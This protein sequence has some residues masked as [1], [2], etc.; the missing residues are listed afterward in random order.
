MSDHED[1]LE[2]LQASGE[3]IAKLAENAELFSQAAEAFR[4]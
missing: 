4:A 3:T 1:R 2:E